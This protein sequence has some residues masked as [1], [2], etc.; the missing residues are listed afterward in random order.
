MI[1]RYMKYEGYD[2]AAEASGKFTDDALISDWA[3]DS[4][5]AAGNLE[6]IVGYEDGSFRPQGS[7]TRAEAAAMFTRL[8]YALLKEK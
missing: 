8:I 5:A 2:I 6:I 7:A 3:Y 1:D 4:V